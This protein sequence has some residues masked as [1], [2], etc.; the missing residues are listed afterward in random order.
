MLGGALVAISWPWVFWFN[1]PFGLLGAPW[2]ALV[3]RELAR[4]DAVRGLDVPGT[5]T[6]VAGLT[7]LV[8]GISRGGITAWNDPLVIVSLVLAAVLLPAFVLDRVAQPGADARS[9]R[10]S[11]TACSARRREPRS[12]TA[13][14]AS[15]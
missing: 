1:V 4:P 12:S 8:L 3:L 5:L 7:G 15:R 6:F 10:S 9:A 2:G 11:A 14:R 13:C